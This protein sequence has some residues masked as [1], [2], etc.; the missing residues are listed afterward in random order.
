MQPISHHDARVAV[1]RSLGVTEPPTTDVPGSS[2]CA[3]ALRAALWADW[4]GASFPVYISRLL[5]TA[6][7]MLLPWQATLPEDANPIHEQL[8]H[9]LQD[10]EATGDVAMLPRGR[11][12]PVPQRVVHL[13]AIG[14]WLLLGGAPSYY[15]PAAASAALERS[16][17]TRLLCRPPADFGLDAS[18]LSEQDWLQTPGESLEDWGRAILENSTLESAG[19]LDVEI[20]APILAGFA[21]TQFH[22]W[23][24]CSS[25]LADG[26]YVAR[27]R[28]R[29]GTNVYYIVQLIAGNVVATGAPQ[30]GDGDIRRL[31]YAIDL[32]SQKPIRV[33][34]FKH[35]NHWSFKLKSA[36]PRAEQRLFLTIGREHQSVDGA[37]YPRWW[38]ISTTYVPSAIQALENLGI[39]VDPR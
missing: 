10:M 13:P 26:R 22:R 6:A 31:Q 33:V 35:K 15:W 23:K 4:S 32:L 17:V 14:R 2:L 24:Q 37:Y 20:Y 34:T 18:E 38:D 39:E 25:K 19:S 29:R 11:W 1:L 9:T 16:G 5:N 3:E 28:M 27:A 12:M 30:L 36:L 8:R 7:R 21:D